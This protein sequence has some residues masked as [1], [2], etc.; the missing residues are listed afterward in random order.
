MQMQR[1]LAGI[2][3]IAPGIDGFTDD[4]TAYG[5]QMHADLVGASGARVTGDPAVG[6]GFA[7]YFIIGNGGLAFAFIHFHPPAA[8]SGALF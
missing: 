4:G 5:R 7:Q 8:F 1:G 6:G 2:F 3:Q